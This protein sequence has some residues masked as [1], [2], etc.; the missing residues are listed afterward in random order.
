MSELSIIISELASIQVRLETIEVMTDLKAVMSHRF[1]TEMLRNGGDAISA[2]EVAMRE[3]VQ[4][5]RTLVR[6][7]ASRVEA[8]VARAEKAEAT[9]VRVESAKAAKAEKAEKAVKAKAEKAE[10]A[11]AAKAAEKAEKAAEKAEKA[12]VKANAVKANAVKANAE[13]A[14]EDASTMNDAGE[15]FDPDVVDRSRDAWVG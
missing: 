6:A 1:D 10:K 2:H 3:V 9:R 4:T 8:A 15:K 13:K 11:N 14:A 5:P 12:A 7:R